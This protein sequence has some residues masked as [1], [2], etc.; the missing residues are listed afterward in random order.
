M[1]QIDGAPSIDRTSENTDNETRAAR[2]TR[3]L[4]SI[5]EQGIARGDKVTFVLRKDQRA[6]TFKLLGLDLDNKT[7]TFVQKMSSPEKLSFDEIQSIQKVAAE[8]A[9]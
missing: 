4:V 8:K 6:Y 9:S 2:E 7:I 1:K 3:I 5:Q